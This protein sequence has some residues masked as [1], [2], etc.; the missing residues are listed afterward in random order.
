MQLPYLHMRTLLILTAFATV[1]VNCRT[2]TTGL[3]E[4]AISLPSA[5]IEAREIPTHREM[6]TG[7]KVVVLGTGTGGGVLRGPR[8]V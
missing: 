5:R 4:F 8:A 1:L 7:T 2:S 6:Q 3:G